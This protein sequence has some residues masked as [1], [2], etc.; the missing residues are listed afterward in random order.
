MY[1]CIASSAEVPLTSL[2]ASNLARATKS[3]PPGRFPVASPLVACFVQS[4]KLQHRVVV[5]APVRP[6]TSSWSFKSA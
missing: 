6:F 5:R 2:Q 3:K 4:V 1:C